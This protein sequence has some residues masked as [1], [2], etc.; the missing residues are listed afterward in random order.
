MFEK[1]LKTV[2][3]LWVVSAP[4]ANRVPNVVVPVSYTTGREHL[5]GATIINLFQAIQLKRQFPGATLI[6]SNCSYPF[7]HADRVE[8]TFKCQILYR[9]GVTARE[10]QSMTNSVDEAVQ[11]KEHLARAGIFPKRIL[12]VTGQMHSRSA[13]YIWRRV[14]PDAEIFL[15]LISFREEVQLDQ[16]VLAQRSPWRWLLSN[17]LRQIAL[18]IVPL[19]WVRLVRHRARA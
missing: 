5:V 8:S 1:L 18:R 3:N 4:L 7:T 15:S 13:L 6:F 11:I 10:A 19:E 17:V 14:F 16:P 12:V 9:A 2:V